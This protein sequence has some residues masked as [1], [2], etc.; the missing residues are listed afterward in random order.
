MK[1]F[2]QEKISEFGFECPSG[3]KSKT[4]MFFVRKMEKIGKTGKTQ[5]YEN[6]GKNR[7]TRKN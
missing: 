7:K 1:I 6:Y 2:I 4:K 5:K 3:R